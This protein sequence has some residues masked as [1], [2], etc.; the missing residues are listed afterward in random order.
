MEEVRLSGASNCNALSSDPD[1]PAYPTRIVLG[2]G[3]FT[4]KR[5]SSRQIL[6]LG[7]K[8]CSKSQP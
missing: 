6:S 8:S 7:P 5:R 3:P 4:V 1:M 2:V